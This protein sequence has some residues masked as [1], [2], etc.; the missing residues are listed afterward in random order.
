MFRRNSIAVGKSNAL[1]D[2]EC[3]VF[4]E[5]LY[6]FHGSQRISAAAVSGGY[7]PFIVW[8]LAKEGGD[9]D[10]GGPAVVGYLLV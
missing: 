10:R 1:S 9:A 5:L 4:A 3:K 2:L 6:E 7:I 8:I